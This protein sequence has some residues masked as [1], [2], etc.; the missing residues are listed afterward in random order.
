MLDVRMI[1]AL[2]CFVVLVTAGLVWFGERGRP[3]H[4]SY[5]GAA[6]NVAG[7]LIDVISSRRCA[8]PRELS[9]IPLRFEQM[10]SAQPDERVTSVIARTQEPSLRPAFDPRSCAMAIAPE[11]ESV[12]IAAVLNSLELM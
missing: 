7:D 11:N 2:G 9:M 3:L 5:S 12:R 10:I 4:R 1:A 8:G 6:A